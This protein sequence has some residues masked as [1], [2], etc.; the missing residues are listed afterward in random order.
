MY[1]PWAFVNQQSAATYCGPHQH[2]V[3]GAIPGVAYHPLA[4]ERSFAATRAFL[5]DALT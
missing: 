3:P 5:A 4:D 1:L 2:A